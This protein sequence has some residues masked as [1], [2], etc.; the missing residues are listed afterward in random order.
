MKLANTP[1]GYVNPDVA[2]FLLR[3]SDTLCSG[4]FQAEGVKKLP[5]S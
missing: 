3:F 4:A 1:T 2:L 5:Q